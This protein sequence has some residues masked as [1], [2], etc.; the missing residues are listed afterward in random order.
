MKPTENHKPAAIT[1][2]DIE[3]ELSRRGMLRAAA[4]G[5]AALATAL[6][7]PVAK[8]QV[9]PGPGAQNASNP[10]RPEATFEVRQRANATHFWESIAA[11]EQRRSGDEARYKSERYYASF[12]KTLPSNPYGEVDPA[13]F[14]TLQAALRS[15][16]STA[17]DRIPLDSSASR[18][19]ANPQGAFK[20]EPYG[21]DSHATRIAP[22][23]AFRSAALA[24]EMAEVYWQAI[25]RDV[26]FSQY[27]SD[28][29][30]AD[31]VADLNR[32]S[33]TPGAAAN[34]RTTADKLFRGETVGDLIG[35]YI[36]Q[37]LWHEIAWGPSIIEQ[38]YESPAPSRDFMLDEVNWLHIQRGGA[39]L[40]TATFDSQRRYIFNNRTLGEYV[41]RD[42][43]FQAYLNA[44]L[45][46]L[47]FG[48]E[49]LADGNPYKSDI[50]NQGAFVSLGAP[51]IL[52]IVTKAAQTSL[53]GAWYQKWREHRLLR[54]EAYAGRVHFHVRGSRSYELH[55]DI[56]NSYALEVLNVQNGVS[57]LPLAYV[58]GS[59]THPSY[60]AGHATIAGACVTVLK[61]LFD[62]DF[63]I[64]NAKV[65]NI[66]GSALDNYRGD[67]LTVGNE[68]NKLANN[69]AIGRD[70]A[71]VHYRQD[72]IQGLQAGEQQA[73][74]LLQDQSLFCNEREFDGFSFTKFDGSVVSIKDGRVY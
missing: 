29:L 40:E 49:A 8:A 37:F 7:T 73:I 44:A 70:A 56:L 47:G 58:E 5:S 3:P 59:P 67:A 42:V 28:P 48:T 68:L 71:G 43:S 13:A 19:L 64:P 60:P 54:P 35:P 36:S 16:R 38:R 65:A 11:G 14:R 32:L 10:S 4:T 61:A 57:L 12:T 51:F 62:E 27:R 46:L 6:M 22:S 66:D 1:H 20:Y 63:V 74:S 33:V 34:G 72:G 53:T 2:S 50:D 21:L 23:H 25:A 17:F 31:A 18:T 52:D 41:H 30:V 55:S 45:I 26:P 15:G 9:S 24:G 39:P 69:I